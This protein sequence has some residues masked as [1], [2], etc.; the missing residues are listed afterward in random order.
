MLTFAMLLS[1]VLERATPTVTKGINLYWSSLRTLDTR[2]GTIQ[3]L[4]DLIGITI[5]DTRNDT[6]HDTLL[7][8][9]NLYIYWD[10]N[11]TVNFFLSVLL[12]PFPLNKR[13]CQ[14]TPIPPTCFQLALLM[15]RDGD[16][17][18]NKVYFRFRCRRLKIFKLLRSNNFR[19]KRCQYRRLMVMCI[20]AYIVK[21]SIT[22]HLCTDGLSH[23]YLTLAPVAERL[24]VELFSICFYDL[25]LSGLGFQHPTFHM[26]GIR[27]SQL[28]HHCGQLWIKIEITCLS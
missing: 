5:H 8:S 24:V 15:Q 13:V 16:P 14:S 7:F 2:V 18:F 4:A 6:Y 22:M 28:R 19:N 20:V 26:R 9:K 25:G 21:F 10:K 3:Y 27:S 11:K 17:P 23:P 12:K 1:W